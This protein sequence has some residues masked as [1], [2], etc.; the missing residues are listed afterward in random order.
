MRDLKKIQTA[1]THLLS[2]I[3]DILDL[4]K[5]EAGKMDLFLETI[6]VPKTLNDVVTTVMPMVQKNNNKLEVNSPPELGSMHTDLTK[7]RQVLFNL[8]SNASKFTD[9]GTIRLDARRVT[10]K[11]T[12]YLIFT[13]QD[14]GIGMTDEQVTR[15][16]QD[17]SQA[18]SSTTRKYGG[19]G[20]GLAISQR[21]AQMMG[22]DI[23][24]ASEPGKGST[25]TVKVLA[26]LA[27]PGEPKPAIAGAS[28]DVKLP[29]L[30]AGASTILVIDDDPSV[31]ELVMRFL[32]KEGSTSG[33]QP[34]AT[35]A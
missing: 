29:P 13:V 18:D 11:G 28:S 1:A 35:K 10:E 24:V 25:F 17:F 27:K 33:R 22:G 19:T 14:S 23:S 3:N 7:L 26:Q 6:D 15:L 5:I 8:L 2:L 32:S 16:F 12:D 9:K 21:F 34:A 30:P 20:L 31:R 4:S